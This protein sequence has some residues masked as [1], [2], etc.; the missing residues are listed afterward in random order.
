MHH[1]IGASACSLIV[2]QSHG[3]LRIHDRKSRAAVITAVS[4][5]NKTFLLGDDRRI[6]HLASRCGDREDD[7][8]RQASRNLTLVIVVIPDIAFIC[9]A[10]A[11]SLSRIDGA[12]ATYSKKEIYA[13]F[14]AELDTLIDKCKMRIGNSSAQHDIL[15]ACCIQCIRNALEKARSH[16]TSAAVMDQYLST[17]EFLDKVSYLTLGILSENNFCGGVVLEIKHGLILLSRKFKHFQFYHQSTRPYSKKARFLSDF[18]FII[19]L[20][21]ILL[22][23][24]VYRVKARKGEQNYED[25][26][27]KKL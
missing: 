25:H 4:A 24:S 3:K 19:I 17:S 22:L 10:I 12:S 5:L 8:Q 15:D 14:L 7:A 18:S 2:R 6:A 21:N 11:D 16:D 26:T 27:G 1:D 9:H 13:F 20:C 23:L